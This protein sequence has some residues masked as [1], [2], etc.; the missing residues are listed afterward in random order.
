MVVVQSPVSAEH[1]SMPVHAIASGNVDHILLPSEM[2][3]I[4]LTHI[5]VALKN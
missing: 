4:I 3:S 1:Q 5:K 2:P